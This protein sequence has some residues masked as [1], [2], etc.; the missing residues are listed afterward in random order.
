MHLRQRALALVGV[1]SIGEL[2]AVGSPPQSEP[3]F[4]SSS[5]DL[6]TWYATRYSRVLAPK[7][8]WQ[9]GFGVGFT[10]IINLAS[11]FSEV[12][13]YGARY[14]RVGSHAVTASLSA[15]VLCDHS[16]G[17]LAVASTGSGRTTRTTGTTA[18]H[19]YG[20]QACSTRAT[21]FGCRK[22]PSRRS[23]S[24]AQPQRPQTFQ[25]SSSCRLEE[26][27]RTCASAP[28]FLAST[29]PSLTSPAGEEH[30]NRI[31]ADN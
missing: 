12:D 31:E 15:V 29:L 22:D 19:W 24:Q 20:L 30:A 9:T 25:Y 11:G 21:F 27:A 3:A 6:G 17:N 7:S 4:A 13:T 2:P 26:T 8:I 28:G 14:T 5:R 10:A 1:I 23:R 16:A 18:A